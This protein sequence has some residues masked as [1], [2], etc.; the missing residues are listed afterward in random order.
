MS[1]E[2]H[3]MKYSFASDIWSFGLIAYE[4]I[5]E[6]PPWEKLIIKNADFLRT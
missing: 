5:V 2:A 6:K 4:V 1:P 3:D